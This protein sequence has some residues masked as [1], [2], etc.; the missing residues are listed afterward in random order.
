MS[1]PKRSPRSAANAPRAKVQAAGPDTT[2]VTASLA[3]EAAL[4]NGA[5]NA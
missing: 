3:A 2:Q 4:L 1:R 5:A